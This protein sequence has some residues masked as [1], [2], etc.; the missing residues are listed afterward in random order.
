MQPSADVDV[1]LGAEAVEAAAQSGLDAELDESI[2]PHVIL[3]YHI[4]AHV[5]PRSDGR[6]YNRA[7]ESAYP[8]YD[9]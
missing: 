7:S 9:I 1:A 4:T 3:K 6:C 5:L 2:M 8:M